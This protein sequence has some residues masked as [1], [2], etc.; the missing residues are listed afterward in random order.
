MYKYSS[1][2]AASKTRLLLMLA[3]SSSLAA[4]T[5]GELAGDDQFVPIA[6]Y[7]K[8]PIEVAKG[9]VKMEVS[10]KQGTLQPS[11][12]NAISGFARSAKSAG[13]SKIKVRRPSGGGASGQVARETINLLVQSGVSAHMIVTGTYPGGAKAPVQISYLR[14]VAITKECGDWSANLADT[15]GNEPYPNM[16]CATQNNIA[17]MVVNP[18]NFVVPAPTTPATAASRM[19]AFETYSESGVGS[20][21]TTA[22]STTGSAP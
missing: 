5:A 16:G 14:S 4:C 8:F 19:T 1:M 13:I 20:T 15:G 2:S 10:S 7:E 21:A 17:A 9:P 22:T 6:H 11:Q 3:V 18:E 12:I